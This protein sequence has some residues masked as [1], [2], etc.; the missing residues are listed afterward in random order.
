MN[1]SGK[2][3]SKRP[4]RL[5]ILVFGLLILAMLGWMRFFESL[6]RWQEFT[7]TGMQ[8]GPWYTA[9]SGLVIG[10][11]ALAAAI[12]IWLPSRWAPWLTR[13]T[14][15]YWLAWTAFDRLVVAS[16][17][18]ALANWPFLT[19]AGILIIAVVLYALHRGREQFK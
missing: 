11:L 2:T 9:A 15:V 1:S 12:G 13:I 3:R 16:S 17:P 7:A 8:P 18:D 19:G 6:V 4:L 5:K 14:V 10:A